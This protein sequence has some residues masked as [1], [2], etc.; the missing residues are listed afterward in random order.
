MGEPDARGTLGT[1]RNA[2]VLLRLLSEGP[3]YQQLTDLAARSGLSVTIVHRL[4]RSLMLADLVEQ[5]T[6]SARYGLGREVARLSQR[7]LARM[8]ILGALAPFMIPLRDRI[9][10]T[11][12]VAILVRGDVVYVDRVDGSDGGLYRD[13][14]RVHP[15]LH[16][17]AGRLLA[18]HG[19][20]TAW[21]LAL[22]V[23]TPEDRKTAEDSRSEWRH[24]SHLVT[25][26]S[27]PDLAPEVAVPVVDGTGTALAALA[28]T[29]P[30][31]ATETHVAEI[32]AELSRASRA[33]G[34]M[35]GHG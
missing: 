32:V 20:D 7:Y 25:T 17:A 4:L 29:T 35:L 15:A 3:V 12:H 5:D 6:K 10:Q 28:A 1:V 19:D 26:G 22:G 11:V 9:G 34:R 24:S 2:V 27:Q 31:A 14:D 21:Q 8:P 33:A 30:V 16:T 13:T 18:A 23:A